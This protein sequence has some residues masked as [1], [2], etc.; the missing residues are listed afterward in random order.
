MKIEID[1]AVLIDTIVEKVVELL[2]PTPNH[3]S[4]AKQTVGQVYPKRLL[5][6]P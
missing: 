1:V 6:G 5:A 3:I 2:T 4:P